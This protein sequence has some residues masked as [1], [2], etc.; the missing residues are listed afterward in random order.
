MSDDSPTPQPD[1]GAELR[2]LG[3]Q[4]ETAVRAA[5]ESEQARHLRD[6]LVDTT[7]DFGQ[8]V[9]TLMNRVV[10]DDRVRDLTERGQQT[11]ER[12]VESEPVQE[13]Q[14]RLAEGLGLLNQQLA[15]LIARLQ[16]PAATPPADDDQSPPAA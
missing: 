14:H 11:I 1:L 2:R 9:E 15:A 16:Q 6:E 5:L 3:N 10:E 4:I 8:R 7:R 13:V 12:V